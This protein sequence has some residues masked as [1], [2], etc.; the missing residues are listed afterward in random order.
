MLKKTRPRYSRTTTVS[1][2]NISGIKPG[3]HSFSRDYPPDFS[4]FFDAL[5]G[6]REYNLKQGRS[7]ID[8]TMAVFYGTNSEGLE[9]SS[10]TP[11]IKIISSNDLFLK[12]LEKAYHALTQS[13]VGKVRFMRVVFDVEKNVMKK[14]S[15]TKAI[16]TKPQAELLNTAKKYGFSSYK[17]YV[18]AI[19]KLNKKYKHAASEKGIKREALNIAKQKQKIAAAKALAKKKAEDLRRH[20]AEIQRMKERLKRLKESEARQKK[21]RKAIDKLVKSL[22]K[23]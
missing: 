18:D 21:N 7:I 15:E 9:R 4:V 12:Y 2:R 8:S 1:P 10:S 6:A 14:L 19:K 3:H 17:D 20:K 13:S 23:K 22:P 16:K 11:L 5:N